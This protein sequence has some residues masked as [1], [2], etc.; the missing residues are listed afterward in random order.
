MNCPS[1]HLPM[2]NSIWLL[3]SHL[4]LYVLGPVVGRVSNAQAVVEMCRVAKE[5]RDLSTAR[6]RGPTIAACRAGLQGDRG[7]WVAQFAV[8]S[9]DYRFQRGG[10]QMLRI[11]C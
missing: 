8:E 11:T 4:T 2:A 3:C 7:A 6:P 9:V 5:V 10:N 1:C